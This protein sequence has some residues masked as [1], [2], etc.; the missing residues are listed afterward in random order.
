MMICIGLGQQFAF[1]KKKKN[2]VK[3]YEWTKIYLFFTI[4]NAKN[5]TCISNN[6]KCKSKH[7]CKIKTQISLAV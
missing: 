3:K 6:Q 5:L 2:R 1:I 4:S 7:R